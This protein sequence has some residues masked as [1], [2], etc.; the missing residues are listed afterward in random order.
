MTYA[1]YF[2]SVLLGGKFNCF[3]FF[4]QDFLVLIWALCQAL[5]LERHHGENSFQNE[6]LSL[7][8]I[9]L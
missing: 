4:S 6:Q 9:N 8:V 1:L 2:Y 7:A 5:P 3:L